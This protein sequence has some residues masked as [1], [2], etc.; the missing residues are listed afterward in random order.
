[1]NKIQWNNSTILLAIMWGAVQMAELQ[2]P[3]I[4]AFVSSCPP[5]TNAPPRG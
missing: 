1:M 4:D 5:A 3:N 2:V